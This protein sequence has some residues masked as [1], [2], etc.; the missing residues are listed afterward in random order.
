MFMTGVLYTV[1]GALVFSYF[2]EHGFFL[3]KAVLIDL[4]DFLKDLFS[5]T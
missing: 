1:Y 2:V 4:A 5:N 3:I